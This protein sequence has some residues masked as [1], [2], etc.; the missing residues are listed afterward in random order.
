[1]S[2]SGVSRRKFLGVSAAG[3]ALARTARAAAKP[4]EAKPDEA[5]P[6]EAKPGGKAGKGAAFPKDFVWGV[7]TASYQVEGAANE[8]GRG[9][10]V[11]DTFCHKKG[12]VFEGDTGDTACDHYHRYKDDVALMKTLGVKSYRFSVSWTRLLP[13]GV[14]AVNGKGVDFYSRL[15]DEL[16]KAGIT[17][18]CTAF[19]WDY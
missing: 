12:V 2:D 7:A 9:P 19:H 6:P 17:P 3:V 14:G 13:N 5:K 16:G 11:W 18:M 4:G 10:S 8:D 15:V 1:M